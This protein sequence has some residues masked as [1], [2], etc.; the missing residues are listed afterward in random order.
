[1]LSLNL[2]F[3]PPFF[4]PRGDATVNSTEYLSE[5]L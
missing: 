2:S 5:R 4:L 3:H 1:M